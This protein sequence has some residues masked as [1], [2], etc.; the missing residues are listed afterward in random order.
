MTVKQ[1][2]GLNW[3]TFMMRNDCIGIMKLLLSNKE[4]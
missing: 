3:T 4:L 2:Y 1:D